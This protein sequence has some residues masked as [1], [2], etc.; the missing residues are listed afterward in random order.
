MRIKLAL[1]LACFAV[2]AS[3][4]EM[5]CVEVPKNHKIVFVPWIIPADQLKWEWRAAKEAVTAEPTN[6]ECDSNDLSVSPSV[7]EE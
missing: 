2:T 3:A 4:Q 1:V 7:C 5:Q 6:E